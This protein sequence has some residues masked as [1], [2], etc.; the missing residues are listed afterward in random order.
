M[1]KYFRRGIQKFVERFTQRFILERKVWQRLLCDGGVLT[2]LCL[3]VKIQGWLPI[4]GNGL[5]YYDDMLL[6]NYGASI[7]AGEWLGS[8]HNGTLCK[9]PG[10][11]LF[12][13]FNDWLGW[14]YMY[15]QALFYGLGAVFFFLALRQLCS[16]QILPFLSYLFLLFSPISFETT[17]S[18]RLYC[19]ALIPGLTL[20]FFAGMIGVVANRRKGFFAYLPWL[21]LTGLS[22]ASYAWVRADI[23]WM[24]VFLLA[25]ICVL[26]LEVLFVEKRKKWLLLSFFLPLLMLF[27][28]KEV[29]RSMNQTYY[30]IACTSDF[31]ETAFSDLCKKLMEVKP[32]EEVWGLYVSMNTMQR[33]ADL[34]PTFATVYEQII[35]DSL[36]TGE[37]GAE[38]Y[39]WELRNAMYQIGYYQDAQKTNDFYEQVCADIDQA[40]QDGSLEKRNALIL[41]PFVGPIEKSQWKGILFGSYTDIKDAVID[42]E[43]LQA[44]FATYTGLAEGYE[45]MSDLTNSILIFDNNYKDVESQT[46]AQKAAFAM[47]EKHVAWMNQ[48]IWVYKITGGVVAIL[49]LLFFLCD[50][51]L[52]LYHAVK[53]RKADFM[54]LILRVGILLAL[55]ALVLLVHIHELVYQTGFAK[56]YGCAS[57][58]IWQVFVCVNLGY[59]TKALDCEIWKN[60]LK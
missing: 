22:I 58:V 46:E 15:T 38:Y 20:S 35:E 31:T 50:L 9:V 39:A 28:S 34:S 41:S 33:V 5:N 8:Y 48:G 49:S 6:T 11:G 3:R 27:A 59:F 45:T 12:L 52:Q 25:A 14:P 43:N 29:L 18:A 4:W 23:Q 56:T 1:K 53:K 32:T 2:F 10:F 47:I 44:S 36:T 16:R 54:G 13:A 19:V 55:Y 57:F 24:E 21:L 37:F 42:Y 26:C 51:I 7:R 17:V 40:F 30:G 60:K